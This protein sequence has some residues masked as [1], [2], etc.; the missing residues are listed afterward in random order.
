MINRT[1]LN[2]LLRE[3]IHILEQAAAL[4]SRSYERCKEIGEKDIRDEEAEERLEALTSRFAKLSD[5]L[6]QK[7]L[8]LL[9]TLALEPPGT[10]RDRINRAEK[11][12]LIENA[13]DFVRMRLL[14]N[15]ITHEYD[16]EAIADIHKKVMIFTPILLRAI[17]RASAHAKRY[18]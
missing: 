16:P 1:D 5:I 7:F 10:A 11:N 9:D 3:E 18:L 17:S 2:A 13:E 15:R 14:R 4:L 6:V 8:R 12:G